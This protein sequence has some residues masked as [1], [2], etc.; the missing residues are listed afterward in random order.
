MRKGPESS[1][2]KV[3]TN[4]GLKHTWIKTSIQS[5]GGKKLNIL[6]QGRKAPYWRLFFHIFDAKS[7]RFNRSLVNIFYCKTRIFL[8]FC[9][10]PHYFHQNTQN[11]HKYYIIFFKMLNSPIFVREKT[12]LIFFIHLWFPVMHLCFYICVESP[13]CS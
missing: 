3:L 8:G 6:Y 9:L 5:Q 4:S 11:F 13:F 2:K 10:I 12:Q 1:F 7:L